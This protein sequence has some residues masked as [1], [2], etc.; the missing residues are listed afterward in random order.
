MW[1]PNRVRRTLAGRACPGGS[2]C[3]MDRLGAH[4][5]GQ[6]EPPMILGYALLVDEGVVY[7]EA[8][9][10]SIWQRDGYRDWVGLHAG[11]VDIDCVDS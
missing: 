3:P 10:R 9:R 7:C 5:R 2:A 4:P 1:A 8:T 6:G 11:K